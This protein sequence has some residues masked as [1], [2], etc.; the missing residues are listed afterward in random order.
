MHRCMR[1]EKELDGENGL[2]YSEVIW[3]QQGRCTRE[4][5]VRRARGKGRRS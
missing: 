5:K 2:E 3:K 4:N 1:L